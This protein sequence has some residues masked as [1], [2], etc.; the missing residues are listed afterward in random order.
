MSKG[1]QLKTVDCLKAARR[2][3]RATRY[4]PRMSQGRPME[5][6]RNLQTKQ[7]YA[8]HEPKET[9]LPIFVAH[10]VTFQFS[11]GTKHLV[12]GVRRYE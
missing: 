11:C 1:V 2:P 7:D 8:V 9:T 10:F 5:V 12:L 6:L 3:L 4:V